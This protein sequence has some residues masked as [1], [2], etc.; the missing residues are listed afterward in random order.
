MNEFNT[1]TIGFTIITIT[2]FDGS[3]QSLDLKED[4]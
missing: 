1:T 4:Y 2:N 3:L